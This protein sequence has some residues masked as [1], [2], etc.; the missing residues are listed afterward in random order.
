MSAF[1]G[2]QTDP[3]TMWS[4]TDCSS[5]FLRPKSSQVT[6]IY[7]VLLTIQIVSKHLTF[8]FMHLADVFIQSDLQCIQAIHF[9]SLCVFPG[10]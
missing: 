3:I 8:T 10:N 7:I 4:F 6:F 1:H 5:P 2:S 9:S